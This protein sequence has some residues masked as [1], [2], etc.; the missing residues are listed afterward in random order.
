[1]AV[2]IHITIIELNAL[3][4]KRQNLFQELDAVI[5]L[6]MEAKHWGLRKS[7][8]AT[9]LNSRFKS[10][11][12]LKVKIIS[13]TCRRVIRTNHKKASK[14]WRHENIQLGGCQSSRLFPRQIRAN[15]ISFTVFPEIVPSIG[16]SFI[17][18]MKTINHTRSSISDDIRNILCSSANM[19]RAIPLI[20]RLLLNYVNLSTNLASHFFDLVIGKILTSRL[21]LSKH[22][23]H[24]LG[25]LLL[26]GKI[27]VF[28]NRRNASSRLL[29]L[30]SKHLILYLG[31][32]FLIVQLHFSKLFLIL[33][34]GVNHTSR[35]SISTSTLPSIKLRKCSSK[36]I[37]SI[38]SFI[39]GR[40]ATKSNQIK[41]L[42]RNGRSAS[43]QRTFKKSF[44]SFSHST[45][46]KTRDGLIRVRNIRAL[47]G[48]FNTSITHAYSIVIGSKHITLN[49]T[50]GGFLTASKQFRHGATS[51][52]RSN[53]ASN[54]TKHKSPH[55]SGWRQIISLIT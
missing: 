45:R 20:L 5:H 2:N 12:T 9:S 28:H 53:T 46:N 47:N 19:R 1:M 13:V 34:S 23:A 27:G 17:N 24:N 51:K 31:N 43:L 22:F 40:L 26:L 54:S 33:K 48:R 8:D 6:L 42:I 36:I 41:Q 3:H 52:S 15:T 49:A 14:I 29:L 25:N 16:N 55:L 35:G 32:L 38:L 11:D 50:G 37:T 7:R 21:S 30:I 18:T 39:S 4:T 10:L 44:T